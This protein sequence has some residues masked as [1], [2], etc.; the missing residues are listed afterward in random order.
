MKYAPKLSNQDLLSI[1]SGIN[2]LVLE[3]KLERNLAEGERT[4]SVRFSRPVL[5]R[6]LT[7]QMCD[8]ILEWAKLHPRH[9]IVEVT[10]HYFDG[11]LHYN[12]VIELEAIAKLDWLTEAY[13]Q[14]IDQVSNAGNP[15]HILGV[16]W[17]ARIKTTA[18][19]AKGKQT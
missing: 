15:K 19:K 2:F 6:P 8:F 14:A 10:A 11:Q 18:E 4:L 17:K 1:G 7:R 12:D 16:S 5:K 9:W 3:S 13:K